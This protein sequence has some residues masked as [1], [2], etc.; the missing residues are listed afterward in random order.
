MIS[1]VFWM[2]YR[3]DF[4]SL[5]DLDTTTYLSLLIG[6]NVVFESTM[7]LAYIIGFVIIFQRNPTFSKIFENVGRMALTNYILQSLICVILFYG[8]G[9]G[10]YGR[11]RPSDLILI[12]LAIYVFN[13]VF[14]WL[15]LKQMN[16]GPLEYVWRKLVGVF[17]SR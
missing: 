5:F 6:I 12:S 14:S 9:F 11:L 1:S 3:G 8:Y 13:C 15:Y 4:Y 16:A 7:S 17:V 10:L 2:L